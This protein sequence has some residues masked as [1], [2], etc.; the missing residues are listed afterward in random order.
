MVGAALF[1]AAGVTTYSGRDVYHNSDILSAVQRD[2]IETRGRRSTQI[3]YTSSSSSLLFSRTSVCKL[4]GGGTPGVDGRRRAAMKTLAGI[5]PT[6]ADSK[7]SGRRSLFSVDSQRASSTNTRR[8]R[9]RRRPLKS[10]RERIEYRTTST[11]RGRR[12]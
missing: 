11:F 2:P 9:R 6:S 5:V 7:R 3:V 4:S 10:A 8:S 12:R 1:R